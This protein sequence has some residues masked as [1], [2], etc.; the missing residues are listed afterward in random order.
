[1][2]K[3]L[4]CHCLSVHKFLLPSQGPACVSAPGHCLLRWIDSVQSCSGQLRDREEGGSAQG[5]GSSCSGRGRGCRR[6]GRAGRWGWGWVAGNSS[7]MSLAQALTSCVLLSW[8]WNLPQPIHHRGILSD[9]GPLP[10][11]RGAGRGG[12]R[13]DCQCGRDTAAGSSAGLLSVCA[14]QSREEAPGAS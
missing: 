3:P 2:R 14:G 5:L 8:P 10:G 9:P 13:T 7:E 6:G 1:M 11:A 4:R 12:L